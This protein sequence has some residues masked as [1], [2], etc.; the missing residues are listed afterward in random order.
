MA[1]AITVGDTV[2]LADGQLQSPVAITLD[3]GTTIKDHLSYPAGASPEETLA[4]LTA[5][6]RQRIALSEKQEQAKVAPLIPAD[7]VLDLSVPVVVVEPPSKEQQE[8]AQFY[9]DVATER[10]AQ[11]LASLSPEL[12]T[13]Y[14]PEYGSIR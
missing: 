14:K 5:R 1:S 12:Q 2:R 11:V 10:T 7:T 4:N 8:R 6:V 9:A 3:D 13:R